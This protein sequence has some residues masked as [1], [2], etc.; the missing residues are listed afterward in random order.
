MVPARG[1]AFV[2]QF[3]GAV[4]LE[5]IERNVLENREVFGRMTSIPISIPATSSA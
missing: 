1:Q 3:L 5:Q 4:L 2:P